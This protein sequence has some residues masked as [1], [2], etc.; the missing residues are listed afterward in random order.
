MTESKHRSCPLASTTR[1]TICQFSSISIVLK[2]DSVS[3]RRLCLN[4]GKVA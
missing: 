1:P 2:P 3:L 4:L